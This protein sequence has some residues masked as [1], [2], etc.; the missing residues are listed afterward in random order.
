MPNAGIPEN[1]GGHAHYH[2]TP[3]ELVQ[4][5]SHFVSD[6][7]VSVV[8]GC[9]GTTPEHIRQLWRGRRIALSA[10]APDIE[11]IPSARASTR[12]SPFHIDPAPVLVGERTNANGSKQFRDLLADEDWEGIVGD[13][14]GRGEGG[15]PHGGRLRGVRRP[16]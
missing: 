2:L 12:P 7:G 4:Y 10:E 6:L 9:C 16:G 3:D 1:V 5:L 11:F 8:G 14:E 13:G 15:G